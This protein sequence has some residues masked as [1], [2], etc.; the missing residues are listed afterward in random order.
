MA[1][2]KAIVQKMIDAGENEEA[3]ASVIKAQQPKPVPIESALSSHMTASSGGEEPDVAPSGPLANVN[4]TLT[5]AAYPQT[6]GDF[7]NLLI[8]EAKG[9]P[10]ALRMG[11]SALKAVA[12]TKQ[13]VSGALRTIGGIVKR[14]PNPLTA[15][16]KA[17]GKATEMLGEHLA[18]PAPS[19]M[20]PVQPP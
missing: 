8:P 1:D 9:I 15:P 11:A 12:P 20:P 2:L 13:A 4:K 16:I 18:T 17:A 3:I 6:A 5:V 10:S 14:N 7:G 19:V